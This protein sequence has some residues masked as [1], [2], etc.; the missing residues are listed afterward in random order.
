M[1]AAAYAERENK[2]RFGVIGIAPSRY[3]SKLQKQIDVLDERIRVARV[4]TTGITLEELRDYKR[5]VD[6]I[7]EEYLAGT[8]L[9]IDDLG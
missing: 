7:T 6:K 9:T 2:P 3:L 8:G 5:E 1:F 4:P